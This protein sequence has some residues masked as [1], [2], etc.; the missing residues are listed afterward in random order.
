MEINEEEKQYLMEML[1][2]EEEEEEEK[3]LA[4]GRHSMLEEME[5]ADIVN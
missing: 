3:Q 5:E 1:E 2:D 4:R